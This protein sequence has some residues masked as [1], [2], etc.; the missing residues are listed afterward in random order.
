TALARESQGRF[1]GVSRDAAAVF[2]FTPDGQKDDGFGDEG[3]VRLRSPF[4]QSSYFPGATSMALDS[5]D[6]V[7]WG[8]DSG[9]LARLADRP[10]VQLTPGGTLIVSGD[11]PG[12]AGVVGDTIS[13]GV[14]GSNVIVTRDGTIS[15]FPAADVKRLDI[16]TG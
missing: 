5:Q 2:R 4:P 12:G 6:R 8:S 9:V 16:G 13:L 7:I 15:T 10:D 14:S 1:I 11:T 3:A